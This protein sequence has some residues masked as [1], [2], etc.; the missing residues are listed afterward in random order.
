MARQPAA[1]ALLGALLVIALSAGQ[2]PAGRGDG[3][4]WK[5]VQM[6]TEGKYQSFKLAQAG[7]YLRVEAG[8]CVEGG[9]WVTP[10]C[11]RLSPL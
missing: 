8:T 2:C 9:E 11:M 7:T 4:N 10:H 5:G 1:A 6:E 3:P